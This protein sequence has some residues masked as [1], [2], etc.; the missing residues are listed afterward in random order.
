MLK[1]PKPGE[2]EDDLLK[3]QQEFLARN[4]S[5]PSASVKRADKRKPS[6]D[7]K[8]DVVKLDGAYTKINN[9]F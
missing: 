2:S 5:D 7:E 6:G 3:F 1:R 8:I 4:E 9:W